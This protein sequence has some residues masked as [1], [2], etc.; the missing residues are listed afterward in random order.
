LLNG[1]LGAGEKPLDGPLLS[2]AGQSFDLLGIEN[3]VTLLD[4]AK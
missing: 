2:G 4:T 1:G 3:R